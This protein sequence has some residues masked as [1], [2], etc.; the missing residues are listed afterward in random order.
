MKKLI[1]LLA[2]IGL[3]VFLPARAQSYLGEYQIQAR[4]TLANEDDYE[5]SHSYVIDIKPCQEQEFDFQYYLNEHS[6]SGDVKGKSK[7]M[8]S[9]FYH[10]NSLPLSM[11]R[12]TLHTL[13]GTEVS[14]AIR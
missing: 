13:A 2:T 12:L 9:L 10:H 3:Q 4:C 8:T 5:E 14:K 1:L 7:S 11:I 6:I